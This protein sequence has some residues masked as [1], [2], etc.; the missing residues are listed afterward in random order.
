MD[1]LLVRIKPRDLHRG[2]V[3]RRFVYLGIRFEEG[4]GWYRVAQDVGEYLRGVRQRAGAPHSPLAFD[5]CTE[6]EARALDE[7]EAEANK[8]ARPADRAREVA[9]REGPPPV[10]EDARE[11]ETNTSDGSEDSEA[12]AGG[13]RGRKGAS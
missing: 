6:A 8:P 5:V 4:K 13:K 2:H 3:L 9:A 10:P 11:P 12:K 7:Q 1:S